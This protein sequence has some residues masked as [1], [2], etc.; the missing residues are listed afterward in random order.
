MSD[1]LPPNATPFERALAKTAEHLADLPVPIRHIRNPETCPA[2]LLPYLAWELSVDEWNPGWGEDVKRRVIAES[3]RVHRRKGTR[4]SVRRALEAIF[5]DIPFTL[6]EG[7]HAGF[8]DG[9]KQH[10][11]LH[12]YGRESNWAKYSVL[13]ERPITQTQAE[14]VRRLLAAI[15]PARCHLLALNFEQALN[16]YDGAI[17]YDNTYTHGVA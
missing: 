9:S 7:A 14:S 5:G 10:N 4:G 8:Y 1:L 16:A 2:A 12:Y 11:G 6:I 3:A 15:A 17:R 13:I